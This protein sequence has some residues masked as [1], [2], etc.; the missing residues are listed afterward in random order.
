MSERLRVVAGTIARFHTFDLA[1]ELQRRGHLEAIYTGYPKRL[2][3]NT[4]VDPAKIRSFPWVQTPVALAERHGLM[5]RRLSAACDILAH[6]SVDRHIARTLP[7]CHALSVLSRS[8]LHAGRAAQAR[9]IA[10]VCDRGS[11]HIVYQDRILAEEHARLGL[12]YTPI[13]PRKQ[14]K[15]QA[16]YALADAVTVPSGFVRRSFIEMGVEAAKVRRIPYGVELSVFRRVCPRDAGFRVLFVGQLS[17]RKGLVYLLDAFARAKLPGAELALVGSPQP[18]TET[19]IERFPVDRLER[20]GPVPRDEVVRQMSRASVLVLPSVED[21]YGLVQA[22]AMAC[23]C[24]VI[25][26]TNTGSEDLFADGV[27]GF[28]VPVRDADAIADRLTRLRDDPALLKRMSQAA[29]DRVKTIGGWAAYGDA[30]LRLFH[31]LARARGH[32][33]A[34]LSAA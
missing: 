32:N 31:E 2:F 4:G 1:R 23:G 15:E 27:E 3:R 6:D 8:G 28:V 33:I 20:V 11:S 16:E 22:Q 18:E 7:D 26:S 13:D 24:P 12:P 30:S 10:Y 25:A 9:N 19:L 17:V 34:P 21:G 5:P 29:L 14:A